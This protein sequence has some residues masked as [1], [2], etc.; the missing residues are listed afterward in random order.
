M[1]GFF[2]HEGP[3]TCFAD[4]KQSDSDFFVH[5]HR[6]ARARGVFLPPS[7]YEACFVSTAHS[8]GIV[9]DTVGRLIEA[10]GEVAGG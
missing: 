1:W 4:A 3:V 9:A 7:P 6:A 10:L 8:D 5:F 2:F